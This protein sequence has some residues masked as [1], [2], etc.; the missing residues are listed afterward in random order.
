MVR[1]HMG[2]NR[3]YPDISSCLG[4]SANGLMSQDQVFC[5]LLEQILSS[6]YSTVHAIGLVSASTIPWNGNVWYKP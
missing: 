4:L 3:M 1:H 6:V 5:M 2:P